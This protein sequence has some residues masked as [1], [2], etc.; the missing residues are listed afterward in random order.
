[1]TNNQTGEHSI[2]TEFHDRKIM[3][4]VST[5]LPHDQG[6]TQYVSGVGIMLLKYMGEQRYDIISELC[7]IQPICLV[8]CIPRLNGIAAC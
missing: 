6:D 4:H 1:M 8:I 3:F 5:L 2:Y 7:L